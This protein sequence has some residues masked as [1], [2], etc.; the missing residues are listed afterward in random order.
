MRLFYM[1]SHTTDWLREQDVVVA[2]G[3]KHSCSGAV[4][5]LSTKEGFPGC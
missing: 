4:S 1:V 3:Q 2:W 5:V